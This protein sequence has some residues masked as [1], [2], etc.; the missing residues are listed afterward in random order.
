MNKNSTLKKN[1]KNKNNFNNQ[2]ITNLQTKSQE[3]QE[4]TFMYE[5][6]IENM[7]QGSADTTLEP[8]HHEDFNIMRNNNNMS[9]QKKE[10]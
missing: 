2:I 7:N 1:L 3:L 8:D 6:V 5:E 9:K 4:E 10:I